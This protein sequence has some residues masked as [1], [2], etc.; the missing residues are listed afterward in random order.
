M[1]LIAKL[2]VKRIV[3]KL[4]G[5]GYE[6]SYDWKGYEVYHP[7]YR[8]FMYIGGPFIILVSGNKVWL[9]RDDEVN[10]YID[11]SIMKDEEEKIAAS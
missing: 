3:R 2:K 4:S 10:E 11:Y 1:T 9:A 8:K 5:N 7:V 6:R